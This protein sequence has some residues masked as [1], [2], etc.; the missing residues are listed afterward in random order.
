MS[1]ICKGGKAHLN[2]TKMKTI[3]TSVNQHYVA[4]LT[5]GATLMDKASGLLLASFPDAGQ[6]GFVA[7]GTETLVTDDQALVVPASFGTY[8]PGSSSSEVS[9]AGLA[10]TAAPN[11]FTGNNVHGGIETFN[12]PVVLNGTT[13]K[14]DESGDNAI[15]TRRQLRAAAQAAFYVWDG[16]ADTKLIPG[17]LSSSSSA[18]NRLVDVAK[19]TG[20]AGEKE[21]VNPG[22][23]HVCS[24]LGLYSIH[25]E[26]GRFL[27]FVGMRM[28]DIPYVL[29]GA[30]SW[31]IRA[32]G[33]RGWHWKH[34]AITYFNNYQLSESDLATG[35]C[36]RFVY[37]LDER[38]E[39][40][41]Y[42][43]ILP[44]SGVNS[45]SNIRLLVAGAR[46][47]DQNYLTFF[48]NNDSFAP[49]QAYPMKEFVEEQ[50]GGVYMKSRYNEAV[51]FCTINNMQPQ[52]LALPVL[53]EI[54]SYRQPAAQIEVSLD[55]QGDE[56]AAS[57]E[58]ETVEWLLNYPGKA[59]V[60]GAALDEWVSTPAPTQNSKKLT[61]TIDANQTG[62]SR[63]T[64]F[65]YG[66]VGQPGK[67]LKIK[68]E[69]L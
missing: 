65:I 34:A 4:T 67:A 21:T 69:A 23:F 32:S 15:P 18:Y 51:K 38:D 17:K 46:N 39:S 43:A 59:L 55:G 56:Y 3:I 42:A 33:G 7:L 30:H 22:N 12:G 57:P 40:L 44:C 9:F 25:T 61:V 8:F 31:S 60:D 14:S 28:E 29:P 45:S 54:M 47:P 10:L 20:D 50:G 1:L 26:G 35:R 66:A 62:E 41:L 52:N 19:Y 58:G 27:A 49:L 5:Q 37:V 48:I 53:K 64:W 24:S 36:R 6:V 11:S 63:W 68:Q 13:S 2:D 16:F